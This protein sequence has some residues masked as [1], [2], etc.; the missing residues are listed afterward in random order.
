[1]G[2]AGSYGTSLRRID[3]ASDYGCSTNICFTIMIF[4]SNS[5]KRRGCNLQSHIRIIY[6]LPNIL[7]RIEAW[8]SLYA[9][10]AGSISGGME[11]GGSTNFIKINLWRIN[12]YAI[13]F[14]N[15]FTSYK[16]PT[17]RSVGCTVSTN[18]NP[19]FASYS[20]FKSYE[21]ICISGKWTI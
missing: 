9:S 21:I 15:S 19:L 8:Y 7:P 17:Y 12:I 4:G 5:I 18:A 20:I 2:F 13:N 6:R 14:T 3:I 10:R 11:S 16:F 1:M